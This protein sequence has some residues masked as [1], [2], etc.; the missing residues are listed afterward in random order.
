M[1]KFNKK[2]VKEKAHNLA[3][4]R[5]YKIST[6]EELVG[7]LLTNFVKSQFY[8]SEDKG[9][10]DLKNLIQSINDKKFIAKAAI[11]ART[12]FGMRSITHIT[13]GEIANSVKG[14]QWTKNFF[15]RVIYR[16]DDASEILAYYMKEYGK[17][18]PNSLKKGL[19]LGLNK[20]DSYQLAKYRGE[21]KDIKLVDILNLIHPK[22]RDEYK[23]LINGNM[24]SVDTWESKLTAAGKQAEN[25][26]DLSKLKSAAWLSLFK[27][28]KIGLFACIRNLRNLEKQCPEAIPLACDL[29][30]NNEV[31]KKSLILPFRFNTAYKEINDRRLKAAL[32]DALDISCSNVPKFDGKTLIVIDSSGSMSGSP[33]EIA[34]LFGTILYKSNDSDMMLFSEHANYISP[35]PR[36]SVMTI[37]SGIPFISGGT[38]FHSIFNT[39]NKRYDRV[40][41]LSDMQGWMGYTAPTMEFNT[42]KKRF[43]CDPYIYSWNLAQQDGTAQFDPMNK[44]VAL[45]SGF[46][47]KV[48]DIM[49]LIETDKNALINEIEKVEL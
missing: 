42:Y 6:K 49:K 40:I 20:F 12:K 2:V 25:E 41:I 3:G 14:E 44:K 43:N 26:D 13:S 37:K 17:P 16:P 36:D 30:T 10:N 29:M 7:N 24:K 1:T 15:S 31:V 35:N 18:I 48:F 39:A 28:N 47:E 11:Y 23:K 9:V 21:N 46:S 33:S 4:G 38:N 5:A 45:L 8:R 27:E 22:H 34:T 32:S 19:A